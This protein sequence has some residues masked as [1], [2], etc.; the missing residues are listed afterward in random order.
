MPDTP[1]LAGQ[2]GHWFF[3]ELSKNGG[4]SGQTPDDHGQWYGSMFWWIVQYIH[5]RNGRACVGMMAFN[6]W[7]LV[8]AVNHL[9]LV[10][11][12]PCWT[13]LL[14][15]AC[16]GGPIASCFLW[17]ACSLSH[18]QICSHSF[19]SSCGHLPSDGPYINHSI[20]KIHE[21]CRSVRVPIDRYVG[22]SC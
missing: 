5:G 14:F 11:S 18:N 9:W 19:Y 20:F 16:L 22:T 1:C 12:L 15:G 2:N 3:S 17:F 13:E 21:H 7:W 4:C 6:G 8:L 10:W